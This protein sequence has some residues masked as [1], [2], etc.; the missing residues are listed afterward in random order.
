MLSYVKSSVR[1]TKSSDSREKTCFAFKLGKIGMWNCMR[2]EFLRKSHAFPRFAH[3]D[4]S[5]LQRDDSVL[6][7]I[8]NTS[9]MRYSIDCFDRP[10]ES[11]WSVA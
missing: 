1:Y 6:E 2:S 10:M 3:Y 4:M 9:A 8:R 7:E 11:V 5:C